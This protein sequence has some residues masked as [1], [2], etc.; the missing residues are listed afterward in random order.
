MCWFSPLW[1]WCTHLSGLIWRKW[2]GI[3]C[4][5]Y[6]GTCCH[7]DSGI[8]HHWLTGI[9]RHSLRDSSTRWMTDTLL[10]C[11]LVTLLLVAFLMRHCGTKK[12]TNRFRNAVLT[13]AYNAFLTSILSKQYSFISIYFD[14]Y[15]PV[16][17]LPVSFLCVR[18]IQ[19]FTFNLWLVVLLLFTQWQLLWPELMDQ[20]VLHA[21]VASLKAV[22]FWS[23]ESIEPTD[24]TQ[25]TQWP[26]K[27]WMVIHLL[28]GVFNWRC[29]HSAQ[30]LVAAETIVGGRQV[31]H[32]FMTVTMDAVTVVTVTLLQF[33]PNEDHQH[34]AADQDH[35]NKEDACA[36]S[37]PRESTI[38]IF[39]AFNNIII[40]ARISLVRYIYHRLTPGGF[41]QEELAVVTTVAWHTGAGVAA[42]TLMAGGSIVAG[43]VRAAGD[44]G[45]AVFAGI[46][47]RRS[48]V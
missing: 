42:A 46:T 29:H 40:W 9:W 21:G 5:W 43:V 25:T 33:D 8:Q 22:L 34:G 19:H 37:R 23:A 48:R 14:S 18:L 24:S 15:V 38:I 11:S 41:W 12:N 44:G 16:L 3:W 26:S 36:H 32:R 27:L 20:V 7:W 6:S 45:A 13:V 47:C 28:I 30:L 4:R 35:K 39:L 17:S 2:T 31:V 10:R 1:R